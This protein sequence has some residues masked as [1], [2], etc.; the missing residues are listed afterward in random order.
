MTNCKLCDKNPAAEILGICKECL[1][2]QP[3]K[4]LVYVQQAHGKSRNPLPAEPPRVSGGAT[5]QICAHNCQISP[6]EWGFCGL[7]ANKEGRLI[8]LGGTPK[9]GIVSW[10]YDPLPTNC[11]AD[12]I[13][14]AGSNSGYPNYSYKPGEEF[15]YKNLAVFLGACSFD[16]L[17]CQ[18][19]SYHQMT[20]RL[21]PVATAEQLAQAVDARTACVCYFGGDPSPQM[22]FALKASHLMLKNKSNKILRIC[23]ETNGNIH[24]RFLKAI[25]ELSLNSG[26]CIKFDLKAWNNHLHKALTGVSNQQTLANFAAL[27]EYIKNRPDPPFLVASTL[28][29]PG[30]IDPEEVGAIAKFIISLNRD[31]PYSLLAF[32]PSYLMDD[33]P[34]TSLQQAQECYETAV[35]AGLSRI[36]LGNINLACFLNLFP[37]HGKDLPASTEENSPAWSS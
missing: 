36:K 6:G 31:I 32:H 5:C 29:V 7:R 16:C 24:P 23:W 10:Y 2:E 25:A 8:Q 26:G 17:F 12:W 34:P 20:R 27:A 14:P 13:C 3:E 30:Y 4:A 1:K 9:R 33:L 18:N 15:G 21:Y 22:P 37:I 11:V 28:L 35:K 19:D